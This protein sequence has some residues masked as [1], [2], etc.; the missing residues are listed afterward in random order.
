[1]GL[2][3]F[4][5]LKN[6]S[7]YVTP[8]FPV[9]QTKRYKFGLFSILSIVGIY[10]ILV[11]VIV[12]LILAFT[13]AKEAVYIFE[14]EKI[15]EQSVRITELEEKI[16]FLTREMESLVSTNRRLKFAMIL[17]NSDSLDST[18]AVYDSLR[19]ENKI[20]KLKREGNIA[21]V[22]WDL[23]E[24]L[25]ATEN[26]ASEKYFLS[27]VRGGL[28]KNFDPSKGHFGIDF[29][30]KINTPIYAAAGG[31]VIFADYTVDDG[32]M[33]IIQHD[34][35]FISIYKHCASLTKKIRDVVVQGELIG[36]TGNSGYNTSGAHLHFEIW[37]D[38]KAVNPDK[39][40]L[41]NWE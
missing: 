38:G 5:E 17:A 9:L 41:K 35:N 31:I 24:K 40:L 22:F 4:E 7:V 19:M 36:L 33:M 27:P 25:A 6:S 15:K 16:I 18:S 14:N 8:N 37:K 1:M 13:P 3:N 34:N 28:I 10:T 20:P 26:Q 11:A 2:F 23:I 30:V 29:G 39:Y 12:T 21:L 32:N